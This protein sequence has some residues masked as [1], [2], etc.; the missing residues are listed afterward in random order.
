MAAAT[1]TNG[2]ATAGSNNVTASTFGF[3]GGM[4]YHVT[5]NTVVGFALAGGGTELG[6]C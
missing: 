2:N 5:P 3:A 4:D 1:R 6:A